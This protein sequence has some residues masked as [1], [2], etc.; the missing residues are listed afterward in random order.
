MGSPPRIQTPSTR[1]PHEGATESRNI[2]L[3]IVL[4]LLTRVQRIHPSRMRMP[5]CQ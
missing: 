4:L 3:I 1:S 2:G 5:Q